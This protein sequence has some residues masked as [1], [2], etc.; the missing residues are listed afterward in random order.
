MKASCTAMIQRLLLWDH[1][2][3]PFNGLTEPTQNTDSN[4]ST[5]I[6]SA[7]HSRK[8]PTLTFIYVTMVTK[9][10]IEGLIQVDDKITSWADFK[11]SRWIFTSL[12]FEIVVKRHICYHIILW[13][14]CVLSQHNWNT[15]EF[16]WQRTETHLFKWFR[17]SVWSTDRFLT[18]QNE[19]Y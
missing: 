14:V 11:S 4:T 8:I 16:D 2:H 12:A 9:C 10:L 18:S 19:L 17:V 7:S 3:T 13:L 15:P 6:L 1:R 5:A